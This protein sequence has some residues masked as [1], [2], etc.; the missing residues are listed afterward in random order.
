[1]KYVKH[2]LCGVAVGLL[3]YLLITGFSYL[4]VALKLSVS[5][6]SV[7]L[8]GA[9]ALILLVAGWNIF[10]K[11]HSFAVLFLRI[12]ASIGAYIL[13]WLVCVHFEI[14]VSLEKWL[15]FGNGG[16]NGQGMI[17]LSFYICLFFAGIIM[18]AMKCFALR[19]GNE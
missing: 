12:I 13:A 15:G 11:V 6:S 9:H 10:Y 17:S 19:K 5:L 4:S 16:A 2:M 14:I 8:I 18:I 1:M 3:Q 7:L